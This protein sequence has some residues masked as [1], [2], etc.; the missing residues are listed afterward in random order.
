MK[1]LHVIAHT[2]WDRE[3]LR[4]ND[5]SRVLL[6]YLFDSLLDILETNPE[7]KYFTFDGQVV[8]LEDYLE[9]KPYQESRVKKLV[10]AGRLLIGPWY[11]QPDMIMPNGE[12]LLRNLILGSK[13]A[14]SMGHCMQ[15]GWIPDAFGQIKRTPEIFSQLGMESVFIWRGF[16]YDMINDSV[17]IWQGDNDASILAIHMPLGYG[18][19]RGLTKDSQEEI[20]EHLKTLK[21]R[22][23]DGELLNMLGSDYIFPDKDMPEKLK[24]LHFEDTNI[25]ISNPEIFTKAIKEK[26]KQTK[27]ELQVFSGDARS[28]AIG[29]I[30]A[31]ITSTRIDIKNAMRYY[32]TLLPKVVEP[33]GMICKQ[34]GGTYHQEIYNYFWKIIFKNQFHDS[35]YSSSPE[36]VNQTVENRLLNLRHGLNELIWMSLRYIA[37]TINTT[38]LL[39]NEDILIGVNTLPYTRND[40]AFVSM[41]VKDKNFVLK[42][43][44]NTIVPYT[45]LKQDKEVNGEIE[46]YN[47]ICNLHDGGEIQEGIKHRVQL[48]IAA[49]EI[50]PMGYKI[51]K[52]CFGVVNTETINASTIKN[53]DGMENEYLKII[54]NTNGSLTVT[55]KET[56]S[57]YDKVHIFE[58]SGDD[59][60]EYNYSPPKDD[61][62][63]STENM[64]PTIELVESSSIEV[65]YRIT[66]TIETPEKI[67][68]HYRVKETVVSTIVT[69]ISLLANSRSVDFK[70][71]IDNMAKDHIIKATFKDVTSSIQNCSQDHFGTIIRDNIIKKQRGLENGATE[72][73]LPIYP[74]KRFVKLNH[75]ETTYAVISKG[76]L[77]YSV[78]DNNTIC[79][80]LLR[81][82]GKFGKED[83]VIRPGRSSGYCLNTP[84]SQLL[85]K[86][87]SEYSVYFGKNTSIDDVICKSEMSNTP[88]VTRYI[89]DITRDKKTSGNWK[90]SMNEISKGLE[91]IALKQQEEGTGVVYRINNMTTHDIDQGMLKVNHT[92]ICYMSNLNEDVL[93]VLPLTPKGIVLPTVKSQ[94]FLTIIIK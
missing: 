78:K 70:T 82:V 87:T 55:N 77:E 7:F 13:K 61:M 31:G 50:P 5:A 4:S 24:Q 8:A 79:L 30:H 17:F 29:R 68:N 10:K 42:D 72:E 69:E 56:S 1:N 62:Y 75:Q 19:Y 38:P 34:L 35:M 33:L 83:L 11:V 76:P 66:Y 49:S 39:E 20:S 26:I 6:V 63:I 53:I 9:I 16:D 71:T 25:C 88:V 47:G 51:Y 58:E 28:A 85:K 18:Y 54:I 84:S 37:D 80:T 3:W 2:H 81:S 52:V 48:K 22:F 21:E 86:I 65:V 32:E 15:A 67:V 44:E 12:S 91:I 43:E 89:N 45:L 93:E 40:F 92:G 41:I 73:E 59:G 64:L 90:Y 23:V 46:Y 14:N 60:D 27:R 57:T 36:T 74:M 94:A